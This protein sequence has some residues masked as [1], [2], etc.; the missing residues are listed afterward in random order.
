MRLGRDGIIGIVGVGLSLLLLPQAF[1]LPQLPIVPIGPGF[2]PAIVLVFMAVTCAILVIQDVMAPPPAANAGAASAVPD[3][4][5]GLVA[6]AFAAVS[7]YIAVLPLVGFRIAT[8]VF[9]AGF[10]VVFD[11]P[12]TLRHWVILLA[13]ALCTSALTYSAFNTYLL[14]LLPRGAW[15]GW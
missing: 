4:A 13:I 11:R 14:V 3:R 7:A 1:G 10:Q 15:T 8:A 5:Y 2:Y 9:V 6:F 12:T